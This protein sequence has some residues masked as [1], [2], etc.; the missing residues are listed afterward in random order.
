MHTTDTSPNPVQP[1]APVPQQDD[2]V[3]IGPLDV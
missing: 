3:Q 1:V 2:R